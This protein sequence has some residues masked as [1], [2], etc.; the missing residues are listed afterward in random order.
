MST[1]NVVTKNV[2]IKKGTSM[3]AILGCLF[4][5]LKLAELGSIAYWS[6]W[7]VLL[8][9][10]WPILFIVLVFFG[11]F[12]LHVIDLIVDTVKNWMKGVKK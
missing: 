9:F 8:P 4:V 1:H 6:W 11:V 10:Y 3:S 7:L 2:V 12:T 5:T